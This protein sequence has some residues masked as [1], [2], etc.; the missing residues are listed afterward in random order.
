MTDDQGGFLALPHA[1]YEPSPLDEFRGN[2]LVE[3]LP[4]YE[5]VSEMDREFGS[6]PRRPKDD[7]GLS[8]GLRSLAVGR[9]THWL[10][11]LTRHEDVIDLL[12]NVVRNGYVGRNPLDA[13]VRRKTIRF[14]REVSAREGMLAHGSS[15]SSTAPSM[16]L[17]GTSGVGKTTVVE[18]ALRQLLPQV[19]YHPEHG[20][21]QIVWLKLDCPAAGSL[22]QLLAAMVEKMEELVGADHRASTK[23]EATYPLVLL[24]A[25][26]AT[27]YNVG[28]IIVDEIQNLL[29]GKANDRQTMLNFLVSMA[30]VARIPIF[31]MGTPL[32]RELMTKQLRQ[33]RRTGD[34]GAIAWDRMPCDPEWTFFLEGMFEYQW[35]RSPAKLTPRLAKRLHDESA[36]IPALVVRLFQLVQIRAIGDGTETV[37]AKAVAEVAQERFSLLRPMLE[38]LRTGRDV[39]AWEDLFAE[40]LEAVD[41]E[42]AAPRRGPPRRA[43]PDAKDKALAELGLLYGRARSS[44][45]IDQAL[46]EDPDLDPREIVERVRVVLDDDHRIYDDLPPPLAMTMRSGSSREADVGEATAHPAGEG[47]TSEATSRGRRADA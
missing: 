19:L 33:T 30:N 47:R 39:S 44:A 12:G 8:R 17:F 13:E 40:H 7:L 27:K 25:R 32:A 38:A 36:G 28:V 22:K 5:L 29:L 15:T 14:Y 10:Q 2:P 1:T 21:A 26:M 11:P 23:Y 16:A 46:G 6:F 34:M 24:V 37:T 45:A 41:R 42:V 4:P 20:L 9:L 43:T 31:T 35:V 3:A 18:F